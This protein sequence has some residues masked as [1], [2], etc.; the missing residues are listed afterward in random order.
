MTIENLVHGNSLEIKA[1]ENNN[2]LRIDVRGDR[3]LFVINTLEYEAENGDELW[4]T[5]DLLKAMFATVRI[6]FINA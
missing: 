4:R 3:D 1:D 6:E 5:I 2:T